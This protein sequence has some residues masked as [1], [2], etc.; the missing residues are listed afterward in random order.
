MFRSQNK[1]TFS[2]TIPVPKWFKRKKPSAIERMKTGHSKESLDISQS[3]AKKIDELAKDPAC[4]CATAACCFTACSI[5]T[6]IT[7]QTTLGLVTAGATC[8]GTTCFAAYQCH[9]KSKADTNPSGNPKEDP[10]DYVSM[11]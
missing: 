1:K 4:R 8:V 2:F 9:K 3:S 6:C 10:S 7:G 11:D 5:G